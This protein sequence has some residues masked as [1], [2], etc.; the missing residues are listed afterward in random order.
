MPSLTYGKCSNRC[1]LGEPFQ[2]LTFQK[3]C[4]NG[5]SFMLIAR[6]TKA[7]PPE[8][9]QENSPGSC[10]AIGTVRPLSNPVRRGLHRDTCTVN[11]LHTF[12]CHVPSSGTP[13]DGSPYSADNSPNGGTDARKN[14]STDRSSNCRPRGAPSPTSPNPPSGLCM[15]AL[16]PG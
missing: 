5:C 16:A 14:R 10:P 12:G 7:I 6:F 13:A 9:C 11:G 2:G 15:R 4:R 8:R 3:P 1:G